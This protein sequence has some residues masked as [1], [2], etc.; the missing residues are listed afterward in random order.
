MMPHQ[1]RILAASS[2]AVIT[3]LFFYFATLTTSIAIP[4]PEFHS[5]SASFR[6]SRVTPLPNLR[7][8]PLGDSITF[9]YLST[10]GN[11]Y[12]AH[13][14]DLLNFKFPSTKYIGTQNSGNMINNEN[15][16]HP[17]Y[18]I[19]DIA[20]KALPSL[21][22]QPNIILVMAG[23]NDIARPY[24]VEDAPWRLGALIDFILLNCP[25]STV[26][27]AKLAPV[28]E[29]PEA[30]EM[31]KNFNSKIPEMVAVRQ[32]AGKKVLSVDM[33]QNFVKAEYL[34]DGVH[35]T[36]SGYKHIA[37]TWHEGILQ[38][39][40]FGWVWEPISVSRKG[41]PAKLMGP[42]GTE[43]PLRPIVED[44]RICEICV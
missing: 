2:L 13:L 15:E 11:G 6:S 33:S 39:I 25:F 10:T 14:L 24:M 38:A 17:G 21:A 32:R 40:Q 18:M 42:D 43:V 1:V 7:I 41:I 8:L 31:V 37:E 5:F 28:T 29:P 12:R 30:E 16:G 35:P 44:G 3:V 23:T 9:G 34:N 19:H 20:K 4:K 27:V 36:D 26:I 22:Q